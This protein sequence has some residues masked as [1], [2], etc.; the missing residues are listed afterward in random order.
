MLLDL[1]LKRLPD[2]SWGCSSAWGWDS[3]WIAGIRRSVPLK[4]WSLIWGGAP[5]AAFRK[6]EL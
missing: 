3:R 4:R 6:D 5:V 1:E 2:C